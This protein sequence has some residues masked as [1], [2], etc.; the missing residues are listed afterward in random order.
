M[1]PKN[2]E[3]LSSLN[4]AISR[5]AP[6]AAMALAAG[7]GEIGAR[8]Q[9][10]DVPII[11]VPGFEADDVLATV[12]RRIAEHDGAALILSTDKSMCQLL[13][14]RIGVYDHFAN[15]PLDV[16]YVQKRFDVPPMRLPVLWGL[17]G[18]ASVGFPGVPSVGPKTAARLINEYGDLEAILGAAAGMPGKLGAALRAGADSARLGQRLFTLRDDVRV[19]INLRQLRYIA[20]AH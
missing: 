10:D 1:V 17:A 3:L 8:F 6:I 18:V 20:P 14:S 16:A 7:L 11:S 13:S 2:Y 12:A 9:E 15:R 4:S 5:L 19:G